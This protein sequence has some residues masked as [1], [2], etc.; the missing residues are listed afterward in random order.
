MASSRVR[1]GT[2]G[3]SYDHWSGVFYPEGLPAADRLA[4]YASRFTTVEVNMTFYRMPSEETVTRWR[5]S[6]PP[7]FAF[8]VKGN[9]LI[10]HVRKL[11]AAEDEV[12]SFLDRVNTLGDRLEV[13]LWQL[14]PSLKHDAALLDEF[15]DSLPRGRVR[16]AVEFRDPSWLTGPT[17]DSLRSHSVA[18]VNV[19]SDIMP[20][21]PTVTADFAYVRFHGLSRYAG[22]YPPSA[23]APWAAFLHEQ[24][25]SGRDCYAYF[26]ND[27]EGHAPHD[28]EL[29]LSML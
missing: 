22:A 10:T 4:Y 18:H 5:Q 8:A 11:A 6:V 21:D 24:A 26:N 23:L 19:S 27:F 9:R 17:F 15:L 7:G 2:S 16:H 14:P 13:I 28:A 25:D 1:V 29:L 12:E 3:W 20:A